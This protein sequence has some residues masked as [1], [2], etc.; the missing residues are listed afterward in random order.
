M[1]ITVKIGK[2][3]Q[4]VETVLLSENATVEDAINATQNYN[5]D[6]A[7]VQVNG[8]LADLETTVKDGDFVVIIDNIKVG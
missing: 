3:G 8:K 6:K 7:Q 5:A 4:G 1:E 2:L